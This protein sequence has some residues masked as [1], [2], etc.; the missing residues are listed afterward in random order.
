MTTTKD[1]V[2]LIFSRK[3]TVM[4]KTSGTLRTILLLAF[5]LNVALAGPGKR[6]GTSGASE[7]SIPFGTRS[8]AMGGATTSNAYGIEALFWNPAGAAKTDFGV[9]LFASHMQYIADIGVSAAA[10]SVKVESIGVLSLHLK[11][12]SVGDI[13]VTTVTTPDGT[14]QTFSP[15][16]FSI[17]L[18]YSNQLTDRIA[19]GA[20]ATL[21]SENM[22][23]VKATGFAFNMG[24]LYDDVAN[25][26]GMTF[27]VAVRNIGP[28]MKF[29]GPGLNVLASDAD[30]KRAPYIYSIEAASFEL[31]SSFEVGVGYKF[32]MAE[33]HS[34][35]IGTTFQNNNF[36]DDEYRAGVEYAFQNLLFLRAG[37]EYIPPQSDVR[38]NIFGPTFGAGLHTVFGSV[39]VRFDY[40]Y[41]SAKIFDNNH[42][43]SL[44]LGM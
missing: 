33:D 12:L 29:D 11:G 35:T 1:N 36:S 41:R 21:V 25:I 28:Q 16:F 37:Y 9:S 2:G 30:F 22:A 40:A 4:E 6:T 43:I 32:G 17:G 14:G 5:I 13:P 34:A 26:R 38:E 31:P 8:I 44:T 7:L 3:T 10:V 39:D 27:G 20:T 24:V 19:I 23:Q 15:Q 42:V 18:T